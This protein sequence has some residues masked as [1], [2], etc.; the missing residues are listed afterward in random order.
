MVFMVTMGQGKHFSHIFYSEDRD[1]SFLCSFGARLE[2]LI[3]VT[4]SRK[5]VTLPL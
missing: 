5:T 1:I 3:V 2:K 4:P